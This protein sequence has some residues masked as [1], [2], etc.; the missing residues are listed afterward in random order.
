MADVWNGSQTAELAPSTWAD[1]QDAADV[2]L[3][4]SGCGLAKKVGSISMSLAKMATSKD[5]F[6]SDLA[7]LRA[8]DSTAFDIDVQLDQKDIA[9]AVFWEPLSNRRAKFNAQLRCGQEVVD[10]SWVHESMRSI[11]EVRQFF[12]VQGG[13]TISRFVAKHSYFYQS[14]L[15]IGA[16]FGSETKAL[17]FFIQSIVVANIILFLVWFPA[18]LPQA[19]YV[20]VNPWTEFWSVFTA[21]QE[22]TIDPETG[23]VSFFAEYVNG[24]LVTNTSHIYNNVP[25]GI[26]FFSGYMP[27][28]KTGEETST[29][30]PTYFTIGSW[31]LVC[32]FTSLLSML[33]LYTVRLYHQI[34]S[35]SAAVSSSAALPV[36]TAQILNAMFGGWDYAHYTMH[37]TSKIRRELVT[38]IKEGE[39]EAER[40]VQKRTI[41]LSRRQRN[42]LFTKR[43][44]LLCLAVGLTVGG[45][46]MIIVCLVPGP[47]NNNVLVPFAEEVPVVGPF[48]GT[49]IIT[50]INLVVPIL[51]KLLVVKEQWSRPVELR[52]TLGRVF[53]VKMVNSTA[54]FLNLG[55]LEEASKVFVERKCVE[56]AAAETYLRLV[57][58]DFAVISLAFSVP[59]Y[60]KLMLLPQILWW[61]KHRKDPKFPSGTHKSNQ[62]GAMPNVPTATP[63][64]APEN[65]EPEPPPSPPATTAGD[66]SYSPLASL[67][68]SSVHVSPPSSPPWM[69][70]SA[71]PSPPATAS[72]DATPP[73]SLFV[74]ST[75]PIDALAPK[76]PPAGSSAAPPAGA[77][78]PMPIPIVTMAEE[79][80]PSKKAT[81]HNDVGLSET[82]KWVASQY[83][84]EG[85]GEDK[86]GD[87][88]LTGY[89]HPK[90]PKL[91][92]PKEA[93][94]LIYRQTL[95]FMGMI[96]SPWLFLVGFIANLGLYWIKY[97]CTLTFHKRPQKLDEY[98]AAGTAVRD[99]Y[100]F[101]MLAT[102]LSFIPFGIYVTLPA[103]PVCGPFRSQDCAE[104][105][106]NGNVT[107]CILD[108]VNGRANFDV[109]G[110]AIMPAPNEAISLDSFL[111]TTNSSSIGEGCDAHCVFKNIAAIVVTVPILLGIIVI[112]IIACAFSQAKAHRM[113]DELR[114]A[115]RE[116]SIEYNEKKKMLRY[117]NVQV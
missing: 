68:P 8:A 3:A 63:Q 45:A 117:A 110:E 61:C 59:K 73:A 28:A 23:D 94:E 66:G 97:W 5:E 101:F 30:E 16:E 25:T 34:R 20:D 47:F 74:P 96:I 4:V 72:A 58:T 85:E 78:A 56:K 115:K 69:F 82:S 24:T 31:Y 50:T 87:K 49:L 29:G 62:V 111:S 54:I 91:D 13:A 114:E 109:L 84:E 55:L 11:N 104:G 41:V 79:T 83:A 86:D 88:L 64:L 2:L 7:A 51:I 48:F 18:W 113:A 108:T 46:S 98:S 9:E 44:G 38:Q 27:K 106:Y 33:T 40:D 71:P 42:I 89:Q 36:G 65:D 103:N 53:L 37:E 76:N 14:Q 93:M 95:L 77:P 39:A 92:V 100:I 105:F 102:C 60:L 70:A 81:D 80:D 116:L 1:K 12:A 21:Q 22:F 52:Q 75:A 26:L 67:A 15:T 43:L 107:S 10:P 90:A 57:L 99:F 32:A 6:D 17:F 112:L 19:I 35:K